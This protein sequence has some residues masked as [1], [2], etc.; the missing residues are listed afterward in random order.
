MKIR[1][2]FAKE[3]TMK[4]IGH[5]DVMRYFQKVMRRADVD[6]RYSEGFSPHQI[7]SFASPLGVGME[8][9]GEYVDIEVLSTDSSKEMLRRINEV[10]GEEMEALSYRRLPDD[11]ANAM[12][13]VAAADYA[14][15]FREEYAPADWDAFTEGLA[16]FLARTEITVIKKTKKGER[17]MNIRPMIYE[18]KAN[19]D[20]TVWMKIATGSAANLKPDAVLR[21]YFESRGETM[22][23]F[24]LLTTRMEV[25]ADKGTE[26]SPDF[27][28]LEQFGEDIE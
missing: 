5:L 20:R 3:G 16:E 23:E 28:T 14:V 10:I 6:I 7:M 4:F 13:I 24:A 21:A 22:V 11:A 15:R 27:V 1:I 12:S 19:E 17:E 26:G 25:Y 9:R 2:K 18:L 8:S